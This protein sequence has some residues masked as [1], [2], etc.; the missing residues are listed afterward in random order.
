MQC[1]AELEEWKREQLKRSATSLAVPDMFYLLSHFAFYSLFCYNMVW[2]GEGAPVFS[3]FKKKLQN[4]M[5]L[6][7]SFGAFFHSSS[8]S[9]TPLHLR[10]YSQD[11]PCATK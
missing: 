9:P 6:L 2:F 10:L 8:L 1:T 7:G 11:T 5:F 4:S 3:P